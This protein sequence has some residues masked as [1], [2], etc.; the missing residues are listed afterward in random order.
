[1]LTGPG[2]GRIPLAG[3]LVIERLSGG[4]GVIVFLKERV[5]RRKRV[6]FQ[7]VLPG[8]CGAHECSVSYLSIATERAP[9]IRRQASLSAVGTTRHFSRT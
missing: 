8:I 1:M 9:G 3:E 4:E 5:Q 7:F 2:E 6:A